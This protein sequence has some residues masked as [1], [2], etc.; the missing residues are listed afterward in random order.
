MHKK[1]PSL[2]TSTAMQMAEGIPVETREW[3]KEASGYS[4]LSS[5]IT[6]INIYITRI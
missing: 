3:A 6:H 4:E 1:V 5:Y 2:Y